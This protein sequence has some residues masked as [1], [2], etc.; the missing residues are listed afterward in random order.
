MCNAWC[1]GFV[2][3]TVPQWPATPAVL[4][5][6]SRNVN[7]SVRDILAPL[8]SRYVGCDL[9]AGEGVDVVADATR[10][11]ETFPPDSFDV[12]VSTEMIEHVPDWPAAWAQMMGVLR[13]GGLLI[14]STR[15]PGFPAHDFPGVFWR[16]TA[17]DLYQILDGVA[18]VLLI[19]H[20]NTLGYAC[21]IGVVARKLGA[22]DWP[23]WRTRLTGAVPVYNMQACARLTVEAFQGGVSANGPLA[24]LRAHIFDLEQ[25]AFDAQIAAASARQTEIRLAEAE[26]RL[27]DLLETE[28]PRGGS[29]A[30]RDDAVEELNRAHERIL[31][32]EASLHAWHCSVFGRLSRIAD[33]L[34]GVLTLPWRVGRCLVNPELRR[35]TFNH[36]ERRWLEMGGR[37]RVGEMP[38]L[39]WV[40]D[41]LDLG[42]SA[43]QVKARLGSCLTRREEAEYRA[44]I[45][46]LRSRVAD[47]PST[48]VRALDLPQAALTTSRDEKR[49][50]ILYVCGEFPNPI[51]GGGGHVADFI[52]M[53]S[54]QHDV[55]VAAWY[56]RPRDH[57]AFAELAPYCRAL[58]GL[59]FEDMECGCVDKL[60]DVIGHEPVDIVHYEW[61]RSLN[62]FDRRLGRHHIF[63]HMES[64]SCS[65]WMDLHRHPPLSPDWMQCFVKWLTVMRI[66]AID[67]GRADA[68]IV[69]TPKDGAFLS[70]FVPGQTY[71]VLNHGINIEDF[72]V[73]DTTPEP[74]TLVFVGNYKHPPNQDAVHY[75]M[76]QIWPQIIGRVPDARF[77]IVGANPPDTIQRYHD[78]ARVVV[79]GRVPAVTPYVQ[80]AAV[81]IAPLVS[82]A[83]WRN[84][85][86]QYAAWRRPC[87]VTPI[88]AEDV[89]LDAQQDFFVARDPSEFAARVLELLLDPDRARSMAE[90]AR[91]K[92]LTLY[93]NRRIVHVGMNSIYRA[94]ENGGD[95][96]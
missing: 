55:Y 95:G 52:K 54:E 1:R 49:R 7:G 21:G 26:I 16:F 88:A 85:V 50:R 82:G 83:G 58:R 8:V 45:Q 28:D 34:W 57:Q 40:L 91:E 18:D 3:K 78:G 32:L 79:T 42:L 77:L 44:M 94:L 48:V 89:M 60:L 92:V 9:E 25:K 36:L 14:L 67:A 6:G 86:I 11:T 13:D 81:C 35:R 76:E 2:E 80:Q 87:V 66:E 47:A 24:P 23:A 72:S 56:D 39:D 5:V 15:S 38:D 4:E 64:V 53:L 29:D 61:P 68:Q 41:T 37:R 12:V 70:S 31:A 10:L 69:V 22:V 93:D 30:R 33:R 63:T 96:Q 46:N 71:Y 75:F 90:Q 43:A 20:D 51:H 27:A 19:D 84:K 73:P 65:L 74:H 62:S 17:Q 59:S